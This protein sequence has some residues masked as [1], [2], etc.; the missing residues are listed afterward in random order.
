MRLIAHEFMTLDGV[1]QGPGAVDEDPTGGFERGGWVVPFL[2]E[3]FGAIVDGWFR[4]ADAILLG[5]TTYDMMHPYWRRVT[6]PGRHQ[7]ST[8]CSTSSGMSKLA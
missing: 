6:D 3:E 1:M 8:R 5:R 2:D 7:A 4:R